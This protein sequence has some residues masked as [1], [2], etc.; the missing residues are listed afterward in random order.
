[1]GAQPAERLYRSGD[2]ARY[3][4]DGAIGFGR[5]DSSERSGHR[6]EPVEIENA[7]TANPVVR[8][9]VVVARDHAGGRQLVAYVVAA[10]GH[11]VTGGMLQSHLRSTLPD[12]MVPDRYVPLDTLPLT[13]NGKVDRLALPAPAAAGLSFPGAP[14]LS[15]EERRVRDIWQGVLHHDEVGVDDDFFDVGGHSLLA[16]QLLS[17]LEAAFDRRLPLSVIFEAPTIRQQAALLR[18]GLPITAARVVPLQAAGSRPPLFFIDVVPLFRSLAG[19]L[20]PDQPFLALPH[21]SG[22]AAVPPVLATRDRRHHV[23]TIRAAWPTGPLPDQGGG[24]R[25]T[26]PTRWPASSAPPVGRRHGRDAPG[27]PTGFDANPGRASWNR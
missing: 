26:S 21:P 4:A 17:R 23:A 20:G 1:M 7:L 19:R 22:R 10:P 2:L 13:P 24:R 15:P 12:Y 14:A 27:R 3:R 8:E 18:E 9:A 11:T 6:V 16:T 25:G 5:L